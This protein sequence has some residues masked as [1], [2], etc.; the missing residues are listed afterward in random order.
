MASPITTIEQRVQAGSIWN[1]AVPATV[2]VDDNQGVRRFPVGAVGGL[3]TFDFVGEESGHAFD[4]YVI[5]RILVDFGTSA[6]G[7]VYIVNRD[8]VPRQVLIQTVA[9]GGVYLYEARRLVLA[10]DERVQILSAGA[11]AG[12]MYA[13]VTAG[14]TRIR[15]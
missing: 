3:F 12:E 8:V 14:P 2:P 10:W 9:G 7:Y 11:P 4:Q 13:R 15:M 1:G 6:N 5:E